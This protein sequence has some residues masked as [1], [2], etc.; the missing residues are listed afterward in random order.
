[1]GAAEFLRSM[2][3]R[4]AALPRGGPTAKDRGS[5]LRRWFYL[6]PLAQRIST[7]S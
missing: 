7:G 4:G 1:M 5:A 2:F 6:K 3:I